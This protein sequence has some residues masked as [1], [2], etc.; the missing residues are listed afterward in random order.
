M[1]SSPFL[2]NLIISVLLITLQALI[3]L[4]NDK[5]SC[6]VGRKLE[7]HVQKQMFCAIQI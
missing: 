6:K 5:S 7:M 4:L 2:R 1:Q 3:L